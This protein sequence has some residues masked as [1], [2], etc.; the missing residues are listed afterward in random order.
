MPTVVHVPRKYRQIVKRAAA[1]HNLP[2]NV[3]A[4]ALGPSRWNP[5]YQDG[6]EVGIGQIDLVANSHITDEQARDPVFAISWVARRLGHVFDRTHG[7]VVATLAYH[8]APMVG[9]HFAETGQWGPFPEI[10]R[11]VKG[12][13][14]RALAPLGG[15]DSATRLLEGREQFSPSI[16]TFGEVATDEELEDD[17]VESFLSAATDTIHGG[18]QPQEDFGGEEAF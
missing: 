14:S 3:L 11:A 18:G 5:E 4:L 1:A 13:V 16:S 2:A 15:L 6:D 12:Q 8:H 7:N 9:Q 10:A 17:P